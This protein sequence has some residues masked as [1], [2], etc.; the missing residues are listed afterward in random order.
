MRERR[1]VL[2]KWVSFRK[3]VKVRYLIDRIPGGLNN[4]SLVHA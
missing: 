4:S 2:E 1:K 3:V